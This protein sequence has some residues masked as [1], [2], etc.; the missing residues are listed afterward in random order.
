MLFRSHDEVLRQRTGKLCFRLI[1]DDHNR[2]LLIELG[3][4]LV[5]RATG[6]F[7]D[8]GV[9]TAAETFVGGDDDEELAFGGAFGWGVFEDLCSNQSVDATRREGECE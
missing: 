3:V 4:F 2:R 6:L 5:E 9:D 7:G 1:S 8:G